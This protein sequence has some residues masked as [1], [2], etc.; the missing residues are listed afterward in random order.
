MA[1]C[2]RTA[3]FIP[4]CPKVLPIISRLCLSPSY[5]LLSLSLSLL[6]AAA[7][8]FWILCAILGIP[9]RPRRR[10]SSRRTRSLFH[11]LIP[12]A[13]SE[14]PFLH[15]LRICF[16]FPSPFAAFLAFLSF[17]RRLS[18]CCC[19]REKDTQT[20]PWCVQCRTIMSNR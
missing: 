3:T 10:R 6:L 12:T 20:E 16:S 4:V 1:R 2:V 11:P 17:H 13:S 15:P 7:C 14:A 8:V 18:C 19:C 5:A 9:E